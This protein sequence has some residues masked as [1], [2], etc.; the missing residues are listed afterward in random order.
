M[1]AV[2]VTAEDER[3]AAEMVRRYDRNRDGLLDK[4]E[5]SRL[6][7]NPLDFDRNRDGKLSVQELA[8]RYARRREA[9]SEAR[10]AS[11]NNDRRDRRETPQEVEIPDPYNGRT[12]FRVVS[13][14]SL[15]EGVPGWFEDK[16][17]NGDGQ[18]SLAEYS[19]KWTDA[20]VEEF[21]A[22]DANGDGVITVDEA[23]RGVESG[24][25]VSALASSPRSSSS[26]SGRGTSMASRSSREATPASTAS[27][28]SSSPDSSSKPAGG[29][30]VPDERTIKYAET[31]IK[32]YD[33][34]NDGV[35]TA[36]EWESMLMN[37]SA[38]D[39]DRDGRISVMEYATYMA[40]QRSR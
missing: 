14:R 22:W 38:A 19:D 1:L 15:P 32:R 18:V 21:F 39:T 13:T 23:R 7:G 37:P 25:S 36:S 8:V 11:R 17:Q 2:P 29:D 34:N 12:S 33:K 40:N 26:D 4:D 31:I 5:I 20:L 27:A 30:A 16:D 24:L 6:S 3:Q 10:N 35:L 9:E 28:D